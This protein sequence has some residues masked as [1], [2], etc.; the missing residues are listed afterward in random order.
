[1]AL[2]D[3]MGGSGLAVWLRATILHHYILHDLG[4]S[5]VEGDW[6]F[7][8]QLQTIEVDSRLSGGGGSQPVRRIRSGTIDLGVEIFLWVSV[9][10]TA[11]GFVKNLTSSA[12][13]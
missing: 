2:A 10:I 12:I 5:V 1:M 3:L 6:S 13:Y 11:A 8:I 9:C 4:A 7:A